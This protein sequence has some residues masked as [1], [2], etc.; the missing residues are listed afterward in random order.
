MPSNPQPLTADDLAIL[1]AESA[2]IAGHTCKAIVVDGSAPDVDAVRQRVAS[3]LER[4]P[5]CAQRLSS[6]NESPAWIDDPNFAVEHHVLAEPRATLVDAVAGAMSGRLDRDRPLWDLRVVGDVAQGRWALVWRIHHAMADGM[7]AMRWASALFWDD[8]VEHPHGPAVPPMT[9]PAPEAR[10][11]GLAAAVVALR[12][13]GRVPATFVRELRPSSPPAP[14]AGRVAESEREVAFASAGLEQLQ[15][16]ARAAGQGVT[17]NDVVLAAV[18]GALREW[19]GG[20][21]LG[22]RCVRAKVPVSLHAKDHGQEWGNR[23]SF[24]FV[25]LPIAEAD[26]LKRLRAVSAETQRGKRSHDAETLY[27]ALADLR[28]L[29]P[30]LADA[31]WRVLMDPREFAVNVS[32]VPGPKET[33]TVLG[34]AVTGLYS[35]AEVADR[36]PL[37]VA[38]VSLGG[39]M[40]FGLCAD[41]GVV[42]DVGRLAGGVEATVAAMAEAAFS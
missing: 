5:R 38:A 4:V 7:T 30:P 9:T 36:H 12:A 31:A 21:G 6:T 42:H 11:G 33:P 16:I 34:G 14:L 27:A 2:T 17:L 29:S 32:N 28:R 26:P 18:A 3:R 37:R 20:E 10:R 13:A 1:R 19:L 39:V 40:Y 35:V 24:L 41:P 22:V 15:A 23:D 25:D 8:A